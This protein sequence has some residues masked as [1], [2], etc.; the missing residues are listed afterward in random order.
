MYCWFPAEGPLARTVAGT[1]SEAA[2]VSTTQTI[3]LRSI[4]RREVLH[5]GR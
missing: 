4:W 3:S 5:L 1:S 2:A